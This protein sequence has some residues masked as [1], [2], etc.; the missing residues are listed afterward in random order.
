[1]QPFPADTTHAR[2]VFPEPPFE[3]EGPLTVPFV[4]T[5]ATKPAR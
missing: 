3:I 4:T 2:F 5:P 1:M